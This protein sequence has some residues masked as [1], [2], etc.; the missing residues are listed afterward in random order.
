MRPYRYAESKQ[1]WL[2]T[3]DTRIKRKD[4]DD[5]VARLN[6]LRKAIFNFNASPSHTSFHSRELKDRILQ[7]PGEVRNAIYR[8]ALDI[9][10]PANPTTRIP[11]RPHTAQRPK[12]S[13]ALLR[14]CKQISVE[15]RTMMEAIDIVY[16]PV[17]PT[18]KYEMVVQRILHNVVSPLTGI[19]NTFFA[20][21]T[22]YMNVHIHLHVKF[23]PASALEDPEPFLDAEAAYFYGRFR[24][25]LIIYTS[26]SA[27][28]AARW[29]SQKYRGLVHL[30]HF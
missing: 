20:A 22:T 6:Q 3:I 7:L 25:T 19:D 17:M 11:L 2:S 8:Y 28:L 23:K 9:G 14:N 10:T 30:N 24:Q 5:T 21:L 12:N 15:A 18:V 13:L 27:L 16:V 1:G 29:P 4:V 26:A